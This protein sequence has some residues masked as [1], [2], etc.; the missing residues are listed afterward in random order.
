MD[1]FTLHRAP[2]TWAY[3]TDSVT[4]SADF[5]RRCEAKTNPT[6]RCSSDFLREFKRGGAVL[7][8]EILTTTWLSPY[9]Q[10]TSTHRGYWKTYPTIL[11]P[12]TLTH[13]HTYHHTVYQHTHNIQQ[14][15]HAFWYELC[16][17]WSPESQTE[18][19]KSTIFQRNSRFSSDEMKQNSKKLNSHFPYNCQLFMNKK[20][21]PSSV[22]VNT[23]SLSFHKEEEEEENMGFRLISNSLGISSIHFNVPTI[24]E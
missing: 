19:Y 10:Q 14:H 9:L 20:Y 13:T 18:L 1:L 24:I 22:R 15:C 16:D 21:N 5:Q 11:T 12:H 8:E 2:H 4:W 7:S 3:Q 23:G 17:H 6:L